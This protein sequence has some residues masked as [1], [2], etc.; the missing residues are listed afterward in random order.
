MSDWETATTVSTDPFD[1]GSSD[2]RATQR[3]KGH[4]EDWS[5]IAM[6]ALQ[7]LAA[8][9]S[10]MAIKGVERALDLNSEWSQGWRLLSDLRLLRHEVD[11]AR[12]AEDRY[13]LS[14]MVEPDLASAMVHLMLGRLPQAEAQAVSHLRAH[15][16]ATRAAH[17]LAET[18]ARQG[19]LLDASRLLAACVE[20]APDYEPARWS[21]A[22]VLRTLQVRAPALQQLDALLLRDLRS[23]RARI[24]R[25]EILVDMEDYAGAWKVSKTIVDEIPDQPHPWLLHGN[26]HQALGDFSAAEAAYRKCLA[27]E[28][29]FAPAYGA[30]A[31]LKTCRFSD[32]DRADMLRL[33]ADRTL[34]DED[35]GALQFALGRAE[36]AAGRYGEAFA[37]YGRGNAILG[38]S[39]P[40][41][42]EA[43]RRA[44]DLARSAHTP[45]YFALRSGGGVKDSAPIFI[46]GLPRS[47]STLL[48]RILG[49]HPAMEAV[50]E[51]TELEAAARSLNRGGASTFPMSMTSATAGQLRQVGQ[52]YLD[53][54]MLYRR[55]GK[56]HFLDKGLSNFQYVGLIRL[57]L[58]NARIIDIRRHP[59]ACCLSAFKENFTANWSVTHDLG[60]L[61]R[62][63]REYVEL[64]A[65]YDTVLPGFVRRVTYEDL[66]T[67]TEDQVSQLLAWLGLPFDEA[68]L[69]FFESA[70]P[71][72]TASA[73]QVRRPIYRDSLEPWRPFEPWIA[74]LKTALGPVLDAYPAV[75]ADLRVGRNT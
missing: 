6:S 71:V 33:D 19:R 58:P 67:D 60:R 54:T 39:R 55:T 8:G 15:P 7:R 31:G 49:C 42:P 21:L 46:V 38:A 40:F 18:V 72:A 64:M 22:V 2:L 26:L 59:L 73:A 70:A 68:C 61:G 56:A 29:S 51:L 74:P 57:A 35:R 28:P 62:Y 41:D 65:H 63:Y 10:R 53:Q 23:L 66:V 48:A 24:L 52:T 20:K 1:S 75:P 16:H 50:G 9:D 13:L 14:L 11:A 37:R 25:C 43:L 44:I 27:L 17:L 30:L 32:E 34:S 47:G 36:E 4:G 45:A 12:A 69:R 5:D 3:E